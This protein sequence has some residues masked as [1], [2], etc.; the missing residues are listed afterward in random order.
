MISSFKYSIF[1]IFSLLQFGFIGTAFGQYQAEIS[2]DD[3]IDHS[4]IPELNNMETDSP[5][6]VNFEGDARRSLITEGV[7]GRAADFPTA[8]GAVV[9]NN[10][11]WTERFIAH[12][13][14]QARNSNSGQLIGQEGRWGLNLNSGNLDLVVTDT[15][16]ATSILSPSSPW[17]SDGEFHH[18]TLTI[19]SV[20]ATPVFTITLDFDTVITITPS[21]LLATS[22]SPLKMGVGL[23]GMIDE[24]ILANRL[25][26]SLTEDQ[27]RFNRDSEYCPEGSV[28]FEETFFYVPR[29]FTHQVPVRF[30][31]I[32]DPLLC[33]ET[34]PCP[35]LFAIQGGS[36][37]NNDY[38]MPSDVVPMVEQ[39]FLV[40]TIDPYC[41]GNG[42]TF[43]PE[44]EVS[45]FVAVKDH[46][47]DF[48]TASSM[49]LDENYL[50]TGCSHGAEAVMIWAMRE[51]DHPA[52]TFARSAGVS[53]YCAKVSG[54]LCGQ[55]GGTENL[56]I[57]IE[58]TEAI[59]HMADTD[60]V[61]MISTQVVSTREIARSWGVNTEGPVCPSAGVAGCM[62]EGFW[63]MT[64][65]S[66]RFK[67]VWQAYENPAAP[68]GYFIQDIGDDCRHCAPPDSEAFR[69]G[70]CML[71]HGR[72][73]MEAEC[74]K[75][76][77]YE[78]PTIEIGQEGESCPIESTWYEDPIENLPNQDAGI[79]DG[80]TDGEI[81]TDAQ[82]DSGDEPTTS[83]SG[84]SCRTSTPN[85]HKNFPLFSM[86]FASL[87]LIRR[88]RK[89]S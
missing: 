39:G 74:P 4:T 62:E 16:G 23:D 72:Q 35:I 8:G 56:Q 63:G 43:L 76:L 6:S 85:S 45:Q 79:A 38:A 28:C 89:T 87:L 61:G 1:I 59:E 71:Y 29:T 5:V 73:N 51:P 20:D 65:G 64:Y 2:F 18:I 3:Q 86:V 42:N 41:E 37:C 67:T 82:P 48:S 40:V 68:S 22:S 78:D 26:A 54:N 31:T 60:V 81:D 84:C 77:T 24:V 70:M 47:Y 36:A 88:Y 44:T 12:F 15:M 66:R 58:S 75:C 33:S 57:D 10:Y 32:Y 49:I 17:P 13:W 53:G 11:N 83:S 69:C 30:K 27:D 34:N 46:M 55:P 52:R 80:D 21:P 9:F 19:N 14:I 25:F 50:A 7:Y